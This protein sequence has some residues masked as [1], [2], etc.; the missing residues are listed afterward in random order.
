MLMLPPALSFRR[1][2][3]SPVCLFVLNALDTPLMITRTSE[4]HRTNFRIAAGTTDL[5]YLCI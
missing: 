3:P 2:K 4:P 1:A 5:L